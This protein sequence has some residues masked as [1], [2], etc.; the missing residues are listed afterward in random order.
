[1]RS[2]TADITILGNGPVAHSLVLA[3]KQTSL[4]IL[5]VDT[6]PL[7][8]P[9]PAHSERTVALA[10][11]SRRLL[12]HL[13]VQMPLHDAA[14]IE[15]VQITQQGLSGRVRLEQQLLE[16]PEQ[17]LGE[18]AGLNTLQA[19]LAVPLAQ[20][21]TLQQEAA[22]PLEDLQWFP[23]RLQLDWPDLRV[24]T[25]LAVVADGGHGGL[26]RLAALQRMG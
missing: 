24:D 8:Q 25:A 6:F 11:G 10:L 16:A 26:A 12:S 4:K 21:S 18:V 20:C 19:A 9:R 7:Q 14:A 17:R 5:M 13:G 22:G 1:M 2:L 3:L 23:D 15:T